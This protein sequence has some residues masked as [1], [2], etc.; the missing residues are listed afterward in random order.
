MKTAKSCSVKSWRLERLLSAGRA[1]PRNNWLEYKRREV[2]MVVKRV[3]R[4]A[5][6]RLYRKLHPLLC[7]FRPLE[8]TERFKYGWSGSD[9]GF[10]KNVLVE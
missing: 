5:E 7:Q 3:Q 4:E 9:V 10:R 2:G 6:A 8:I 1:E